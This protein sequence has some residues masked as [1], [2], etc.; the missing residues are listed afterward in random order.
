MIN[1][2]TL[3][4]SFWIVAGFWC[5]ARLT[6]MC[7]YEMLEKGGGEKY[8]KGELDKKWQDYLLKK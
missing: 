4:Q 7:I 1:I 8:M 3:F 6:W 5:I 2:Y